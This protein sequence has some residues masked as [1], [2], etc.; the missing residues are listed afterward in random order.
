MSNFDKKNSNKYKRIP[1]TL[2][3]KSASYLTPNMRRVTLQGDALK[4][5]PENSEGAVIKMLFELPGFDIWNLDLYSCIFAFPF[6][7]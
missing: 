7:R 6:H 1:K 4:N 5:F 3:V 2:T